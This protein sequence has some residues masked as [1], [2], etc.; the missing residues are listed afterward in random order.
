[1]PA[2]TAVVTGASRG[3]GRAIAVSLGES[4]WTVHVTGRSA[5]VDDAAAEVDAA[6]GRGVPVRCDH[7]DDAQVAALFEQVDAGGAPLDL[8]V[9][10]AFP[11]GAV[12]PLDETPFFEQPVTTIDALLPVGFRAHYVATWHAAR[13]MVA[14]GHGTIVNISAASA[15]YSVL[16]PAYSVTKAALDKFTVDAARQ[17]RGTGVTILS[18]WPGPWVATERVPFDDAESPFVTGRAVAALAADPEV[19]QLH[20]RI[21]AAADV[22]GGP[23][24]FDDDQIRRQLLRR[25]P[26]R[27]A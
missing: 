10:N 7:A 21:V 1:M 18:L 6:G 11:T 3:I 19:A 26:F 22:A 9:N 12:D 4:G 27:L 25:A 13:R 16:S 15:V 17:L 14:A 24:P 2:G 5:T 23:Y 8:L 20:G